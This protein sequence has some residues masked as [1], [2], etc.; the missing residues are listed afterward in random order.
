M[1]NK[2][3]YENYGRKEE[4]NIMANVITFLKGFAFGVTGTVP[5]VSGATI[6]IVLGFYYQLIDALN[7]FAKNRKKHL[8]FL[9]PLLLGIVA[10]LVL[11]SSIID[12]LLKNFSFPT[13]MFFV[14]LIAS[15]IPF[16]YKKAKVFRRGFKFKELF[17]IVIPFVALFAISNVRPTLDTDHAEVINN[18]KLSFMFFMFFVGCI[19]GASFLIPGVSGVYFQLAMG[20]YPLIIF[21]M[22][23]IRFLFTDITNFSLLADIAKVLCPLIIGIIVG[24]LLMA[25]VM[26]KLLQTRKRTVYSIILGLLLAS[27]YVLFNEPIVYQSGLSATKI[28][29]GIFTFIVGY[30]ASFLLSDKQKKGGLI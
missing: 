21:S 26:E 5:A 19:S 22:S 29:I 11:F 13:M 25:R 15:T 4:R 17:L 1:G 2:N 16:A 23:S 9:L 20:V 12:Y 28:I 14:G 30:A 24:G 10:G 8:Y 3:F 6:A 7:N 18:I 27:V